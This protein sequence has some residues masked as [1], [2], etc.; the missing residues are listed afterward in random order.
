MVYT[1]AFLSLFFLGFILGMFYQQI[2][3]IEGA[4]KILSYTDIQVNFN[5][6]KLVDDLTNNFVPAFKEALNET[7][8]NNLNITNSTSPG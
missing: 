2:A 1:G 5:E 6:T 7:L 3:I 8:T 4:G